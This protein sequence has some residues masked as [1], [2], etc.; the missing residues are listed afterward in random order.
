M[1]A[2]SCCAGTS[3]VNVWR[4][5]VQLLAVLVGHDRACRRVDD[6]TISDRNGDNT[7]PAGTHA[8]ECR[9]EGSH[10]GDGIVDGFDVPNV[11]SL[12]MVAQK[13]CA[14]PE[15]VKNDGIFEEESALIRQSE[16]RA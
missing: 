12:L 15:E 8:L 11:S 13:S 9:L 1:V 5:L 2:I 14:L 4:E 6:E 3:T 16:Q 10:M 7:N